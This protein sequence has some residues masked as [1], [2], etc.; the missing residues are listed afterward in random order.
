LGRDEQVILFLNRRAFAPFVVCRDCGHRYE[1]PNCAVALALHRRD[2]KLRCHHCDHQ[3]PVPEVCV[4][5]GSDRVKAFGIG[6]ERVQ[7]VVGE[8]FANARV[9]RLDRDI[10]RKKGALEDII[11]RFRTG[12]LNVL[13]GTQM[14]AKGLDFPDVTVVGV[15]AADISL[16][17]PD[18]RASERTFQL[19]SQVA[20]R[21]GRGQRAG[22]VVIQTL[23]PDHAAV[24]HA[25]THDYDNFYAAL[26]EEREKAKYPPFRRLV[27]VV[28]SGPVEKE[29]F[30]VSAVV[31]HR[32]K[33]V[34]PE[35]E[36]LGP[37]DCPLSKLSSQY[38]RHVLVKLAPGGDP[39]P[40]AAALE[41]IKV[42]QGRIVIDVDAQNLI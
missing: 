9:A 39:G 18:F 4:A 6:A 23:S 14:V 28:V 17:I 13:V 37:V 30:D 26:I 1:C 20:G 2:A 40:I 27:N 33:L 16:S 29:V 35:S 31:A 25:Q 10:A 5:C 32:L 21:A 34:L 11:A 19:L 15:I 42:G 7:Q 22:S 12:E 41:E 36:I 8:S 38:R 24:V 3:A